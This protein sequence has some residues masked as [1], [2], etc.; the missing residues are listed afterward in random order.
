M[1]RTSADLASVPLR[2]GDRHRRD[3]VQAVR[4]LVADGSIAEL[5]VSAISKRAGLSRSNFYFYFDSKYAVLASIFAEGLAELQRLTK[6]FAP[7]ANDETPRS[8]VSRMV[9][10]AAAVYASKGSAFSACTL[11]R[12]SDPELRA[13]LAHQGD[14][15][16]DRVVATLRREVAYGRAR[17]VSDDL[18][19]LVRILIVTTSSTLAGDIAYLERDGD[20]QRTVK[21]LEELWLNALWS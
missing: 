16:I 9:A 7:R 13:V 10:G 15:V 20:P 4:D 19:M 12:S 14:A 1:M 11:E 3:I 8:F 17:P 5:T 6:D 2:R 18:Q 21:V